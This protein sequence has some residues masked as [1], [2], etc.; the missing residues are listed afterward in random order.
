MLANA[1][2]LKALGPLFVLNRWALRTTTKPFACSFYLN[3]NNKYLRVFIRP[4]DGNSSAINILSSIEPCF[5]AVH[6]AVAYK[7]VVYVESE[8]HIDVL[9]AQ[10][11]GDHG[12]PHVEVALIVGADRAE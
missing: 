7:L 10:V 8:E 1:R 4:P 6:G 5:I 9:L 12:N 2:D 11:R 3:S